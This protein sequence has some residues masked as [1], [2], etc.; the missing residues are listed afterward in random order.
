MLAPEWPEPDVS[1]L[2]AS[3]ATRSAAYCAGSPET[4]ET[5]MSSKTR[6]ERELQSRFRPVEGTPRLRE[7]NAAAWR[8]HYDRVFVPDMAAVGEQLATHLEAVYPPNDMPVLAKYGCTIIIT[9]VDVRIHNANSDR[10]DE[11]ADIKLGRDVLVPASYAGLSCGGPRF[12]RY[13]NRGVPPERAAAIK[14]GTDDY[15]K[16]W[17]VFCADQDKKERERVPETMEPFFSRFVEERTRYKTENKA[18]MAWP[19]QRKKITGKYPTWGE[20][21]SQF[22][23]FGDYFKTLFGEQLSVE[24]ACDDP[25]AS[26]DCPQCGAIDRLVV[27][28]ATD[29]DTGRCGQCDSNRTDE[30]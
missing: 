5:I 30:L 20:I 8:A 22:I 19:A 7:M 27:D 17:D 14:A 29:G 11:H 28:V 26:K 13:P 18:I 16:S 4:D 10:W 12:S 23:V 21:A 24:G 2:F 1:G 6:I 9:H 25:S 15:I 3:R